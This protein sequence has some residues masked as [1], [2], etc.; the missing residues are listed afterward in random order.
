MLR[1]IQLLQKQI[2]ELTSD[3]EKLEKLPHQMTIY[4][5]LL[6][7]EAYRNKAV[8]P[9]GSLYEEAQAMMFAGGDTVA[10]ALMLGSFHLLRQPEQYS[11]LRQELQEGW[12]DLESPLDS[13]KLEGLKYLDAVIKESLRLSSGV[14]SGLL[15]VVPVDGATICGV[16]VPGEVRLISLPLSYLHCSKQCMKLG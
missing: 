13:K 10:N 8:P 9:P 14:V 1:G 3:P 12:P 11:R 15:R 5:R 2:K 4:H 16:R 7:Q 6:D